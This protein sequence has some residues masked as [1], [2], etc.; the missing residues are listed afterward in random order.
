[1]VLCPV[2]CV[3]PWVCLLLHFIACGIVE[4]SQTLCKGQHDDITHNTVQQRGLV[5][6]EGGVRCEGRR[7]WPDKLGGLEPVHLP[8]AVKGSPSLVGVLPGAGTGSPE[9]VR[10]CIA[11]VLA[12]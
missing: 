11:A 7:V 8:A 6:E 1:M 4:R 9:L 10:S 5:P 3:F 2:L 12:G